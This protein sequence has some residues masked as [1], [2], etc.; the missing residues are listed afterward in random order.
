M[1]GTCVAFQ[2]LGLNINTGATMWRPSA[3]DFL[4][5][6]LQRRLVMPY[7]WHCYDQELVNDYMRSA[8]FSWTCFPLVIRVCQTRVRF[9]NFTR[10]PRYFRSRNSRFGQGNSKLWLR[11]RPRREGACLYHPFVHNKHSSDT[12]YADTYKRMG[13]WHL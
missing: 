9:L 13:L 10:W 6:S 2:V 11:Y 3:L 5:R 7:H 4:N 1:R 8:G 12:A